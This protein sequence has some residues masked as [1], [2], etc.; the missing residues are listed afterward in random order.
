MILRD[1]REKDWDEFW[2]VTNTPS[3]MRWLGDELGP[4]SMAAAWER[5]QGYARDYGHTFWLLE[6]KNDNGHLSGEV[7]GFCGLKRSNIVNEK[8]TGMVEI[9][10]RLREDAWGHGYAK[11]AAIASLDLGFGRFG[12]TEIVALTVEGNIASWGLMKRLGM[13]RRSD[14]EFIDPSVGPELNPHIVYSI[15][16][17]HWGEGL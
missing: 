17:E 16:R 3:V 8:V 11:E 13:V 14:L 6:R 12:A 2:R 9:G 5:L 7:L 1:W 15:N 4:A 10:W